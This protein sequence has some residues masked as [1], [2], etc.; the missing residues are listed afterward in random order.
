MEPYRPLRLGLFV[1]ECFRLLFLTAV[2][3]ALRPG[4]AAFPWLVY[5]APNVLFTLMA[6]FLWLNLSRYGAYL[7]LFLAGK[8]IGLFSILGWSVFMRGIRASEFF[9]GVNSLVPEMITGI[10][11]CGDTFATAA[12]Y[13][14]IKKIETTKAAQTALHEQAAVQAAET[15]VQEGE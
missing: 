2:F 4:G 7:P 9:E 11:L 3:A 14:I 10:L 5:A 8:I 15:P 6:L 12:V 13:C 1:Y